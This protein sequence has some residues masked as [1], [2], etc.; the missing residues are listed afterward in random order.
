MDPSDRSKR[1]AIGD[2]SIG[3]E[4]GIELIVPARWSSRLDVFLC[5]RLSGLSRRQ[6]RGLF[7]TATV[8]VNGRRA[9]KGKPVRT[10]DV[11]RID[12]HEATS[13]LLSQPDL[14]VRVLYED[15]VLVAVDKPSGMPS[16]ALR[17]SDR[18]T[19]ANYLVARYPEAIRVGAPLEVG[20]VHRLDT[21]TSGVLLATRTAEV[22]TALREQF[23]RLEIEKR[24]VALVRGDVK[25]PGVIQVPISHLPRR[26]RRMYICTDADRARRIGARPAETRYRPL[27]RLGSASLVAVS[28]STGVRHQI[29]VHLASIGHPVLGD[30]LYD[31]ACPAPGVVPRT[32]L[33]ARRI[34]FRHPVSDAVVLVEAPI[35]PDFLAVIRRLE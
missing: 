19:V 11:V 4:D 15:P 16:L 24:Y 18:D 20:L 14:P 33:H 1:S 7:A 2:W 12:F 27:A 5:G 34:G 31:P 8:K 26:P 23:R 10:G 22:H 29:R 25:E 32:M 17:R 9:A 3:A 35:P 13:D 28:I 30:P 21:D 6:S